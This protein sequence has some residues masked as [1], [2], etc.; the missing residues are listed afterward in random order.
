MQNTE[1]LLLAIKSK[2]TKAIIHLEYSALRTKNHTTDPASMSE[3]ELA[4]WESFTARFSR[5]AE[6]F[7][8]RYL[9]TKLLH[10]DPGFQGSFRDQLHAAHKF[11]LISEVDPWLV[12]REMRNRMA[13]EYEDARLEIL[14]EEVRSR[15]PLLLAIRESLKK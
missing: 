4:D 3:Q 13:H 2:L 6:L 7:L 10:L 12:I 1:H 15:T 11:G 9:R 14:F 8:Q 5:V